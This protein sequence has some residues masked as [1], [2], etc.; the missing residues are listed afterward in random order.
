MVP[1]PGIHLLLFNDIECSYVQL[2][3]SGG[4]RICIDDMQVLFDIIV[5]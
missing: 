4:S 3:K 5:Q 1:D 2:R